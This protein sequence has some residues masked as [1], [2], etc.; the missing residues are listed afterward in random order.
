[1]ASLGAAAKQLYAEIVLRD[2]TGEGAASAA[3]NFGKVATAADGAA[4]TIERSAKVTSQVER[5]YARLERALDPLAAANARFQRDQEALRRAQEFGVITADRYRDRLAQLNEAHARAKDRIEQHKRGQEGLNRTVGDFS[6]VLNIAKGALAG[7]FAA[8]SF[9]RIVRGAKD[10]VAAIAELADK[11]RGVGGIDQAGFLQEARFALGQ[12]GFEESEADKA[13]GVLNRQVGALRIGGGAL[14]TVL[15]RIEGGRELAAQL[16]QARDLREQYELIVGAL[17]KM[18][19][20]GQRAV[21][22]TAAFGKDAG[23][24]FGAAAEEGVEGFRRLADEARA[25]GL[26]LDQDVI[27]RADALDDRLRKATDVIGVQMRRAFVELGPIIVGLIELV[28]QFLK[29]AAD[30]VR[31][32]TLGFQDPSKTTDTGTLQAQREQALKE[33]ARIDAANALNASLGKG[34]PFDFG[35]YDRLTERLAKIDRQL[36]EIQGGGVLTFQQLQDKL[37]SGTIEAGAFGEELDAIAKAQ[38]ALAQSERELQAAKGGKAALEEFRRSES[39]TASLDAAGLVGPARDELKKLLEEQVK[40]TA[41]TKRLE[42]TWKRVAAEI[43]KAA[44]VRFEPLAD[45]EADNERLQALIDAAAIGQEE[46][47]RTKDRFEIEDQIARLKLEAGRANRTLSDDEIARLEEQLRLN[48]ELRDKFADS[49]RTA[50]TARRS[51][52]AWDREFRGVADRFFDH[53]V[54]TGRF[55][56]KGLAGDFKRLFLDALLSPVRNLFGNIISGAFGGGVFTPGINGANPANVAGGIFGGVG[57]F[58]SRLAPTALGLGGLALG[59]ASSVFGLTALLGAQNLASGVAGVA[60]FFGAPGGVTDFLLG[61]FNG[62]SGLST[63]GTPLGAL[64]GIGGSLLSGAL[65]GNSKA[66]SIGSTIGGLAGS[67]IPIPVL[68]PLIGSFLG[69]ALGSLFAGKPSNKVGQVVF[70]AA[71]G[72][73]LGSASKDQSEKAVENLKTAQ[74][75]QNQI[76]AGIK[77]I[78]RLTGGSLG[79]FLLNTEVGTRGIRIGEQGPA[80]QILGAQTFSADEAGAQEA[81]LAGLKLALDRL[82]GAD[83]ALA[84]VTKQLA[85]AGK[86]VEEIITRLTNIK[87]AIAD[88][89]EFVDPLKGRID[90]IIEAFSGLDRSAGALKD[91]FDKAIDRLAESIEAE[92]RKAILAE[93]NPKLAAIEE[94]LK[95]QAARRT[96]IERL[97]GEGG[98]VDASLIAEFQRRQLLNQF[99]AADRFAQGTDPAKFAIEKLVADQAAERVAFRRAIEGSGGLL[100]EAD[101]LTLIRAQEV[102]RFSAFKSLPDEDKLRLAG[103]TD[104]DDLSKEYA[105]AVER[106]IAETEKLTENFEEERR[107]LQESISARAGEVANLGGAIDRLDARSLTAKP[108][109]LPEVLRGRLLDLEQRALSSDE[110]TAAAARAELPGAVD[111]FVDRLESLFASGSE[112]V[113]GVQFARDILDR[114]R[115]RASEEQSL[116]QRQLDELEKSRTTLEQIRDLMAAPRLDIAALVG[117]TAG[118]DPSNPVSILALQLADLEARQ[119]AQNDRLIAALEALTP[120]DVGLDAT[121]VSASAV[122]ASGG[123]FG[124]GGTAG[125]SEAAAPAS[126]LA[127]SRDSEIAAALGGVETAVVNLEATIIELD[128]NRTPREE[129]DAEHLKII[130]NRKAASL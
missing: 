114:V 68:G 35:E 12:Q 82:T 8:F 22:A 81:V 30:G 72:A 55:S 15:P 99:G 13:L 1:M 85:N 71:T 128:R 107:R 9:D 121:P 52:E 5:A 62:K 125:P 80:G 60:N 75:I 7:F 117:A 37:R 49:Q 108:G 59:G 90:A 53:F 76:S 14:S 106:L 19:D 70:D 10:A 20:A 91:A 50:E 54:E 67:F 45:L 63:L 89:D 83:A 36:K 104:F 79:G 65:F 101:F 42:E 48:R 112:T 113:A 130:A 47:E 16:K 66:Q 105:L 87:A 123:V 11:A 73:T 86:P 115:T 2:R 18:E 27:A 103:R 127:P 21:L 46:L 116:A 33:I 120:A 69:G 77:E 32:L 124:G 3:A 51:A 129:R 96:E 111:L 95:Q 57:G 74:N 28:A 41:E 44:K 23:L 84:E 31:S 126:S 102:E 93:D 24:K 58:G 94:I 78:V 34:K 64:G 26:V 118:L 122:T 25:A 29:S 39:V 119:T 109:A 17:N 88:P 110:A 92:A 40:N 4:T 43:A 98:N 97:A 61:G 100:T 56:F 38:A 6:G